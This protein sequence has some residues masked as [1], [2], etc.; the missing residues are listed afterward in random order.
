MIKFRFHHQMMKKAFVKCWQ[1]CYAKVPLFL[2]F[3]SLSRKTLT[4][5]PVGTLFLSIIIVRVYLSNFGLTPCYKN[6]SPLVTLTR[7][8]HHFP[9]SL[10]IV[11]LLKEIYLQ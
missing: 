6:L 11:D 9:P 8:W 10:F 5:H 1:I 2:L 3:L 7:L 4:F